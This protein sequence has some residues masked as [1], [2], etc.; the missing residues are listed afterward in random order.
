MNL[1]PQ[2]LMIIYMA[3]SLGCELSDHGKERTGKYSFWW[4]VL[5]WL[6]IAVLL[7]WGGFWDALEITQ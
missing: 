4:A 2:I 6:I 5:S 1:W 7:D 3:S